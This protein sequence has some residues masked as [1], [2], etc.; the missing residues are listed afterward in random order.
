MKLQVEGNSQIG[1]HPSEDLALKAVEVD[2]K[3]GRFELE[4]PFVR[5]RTAAKDLQ[6]AQLAVLALPPFGSPG[7]A[8]A[9]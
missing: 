1:P 7:P 5:W 6:T 8:A 3:L 9:P 2:G 4:V